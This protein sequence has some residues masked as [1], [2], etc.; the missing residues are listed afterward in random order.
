MRYFPTVSSTFVTSR[1]RS[2][3][4]S[5]RPLPSL[6]EGEEFHSFSSDSGKRHVHFGATECI[7]EP[8]SMDVECQTEV[9]KNLSVA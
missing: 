3:D 1:S 6:T 7:L 5:L 2:E 8:M 9:S 4:H